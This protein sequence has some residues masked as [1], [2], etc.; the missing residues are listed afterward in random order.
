M[1]ADAYGER[2]LAIPLRDDEGR[3][4][5]VLDISIGTL[6]TLPR[7]ESREVMK[8][9]KLLQL[10]YK[11]ISRESRGGER[12]ASVLEGEQQGDDDARTDILF[13]K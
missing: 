12:S 8:M 13:D 2:H 7:A 5:I 11:E 4:I 6:K 1:T 10:A 3:A 9:L